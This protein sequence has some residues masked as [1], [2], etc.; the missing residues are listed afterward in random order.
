MRVL[1]SGGTGFIG[2]PFVHQ[3]LRGRHTVTVLCRDPARARVTLPDSVALFRYDMVTPGAPDPVALEGQDLFVHLA[4]TGLPNYKNTLHGDVNLPASLALCRAVLDAGIP[5]L[6]VAGTCMEFGVGEGA[7]RPDEEPSPTTAYAAAKDQ[8]RRTLVA[9]RS[10]RAFRLQWV[11]IFYVYGPGQ[12]PNSLIAQLDAA[13]ARGDQEFPMS[14][15]RH[16]R[17]YLSVEDVAAGLVRVVE[18]PDLEGPLHVCSG[19]PTTIRDLVEAHIRCR[20]VTIRPRPGAFPDPEGEP[21]AFWGV[22]SV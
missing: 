1:V 17:D 5:R 16:A 22:P 8:L 3:L 18:R 12:N 2:R 7:R 4:W 13:I 6:L 15:G 19:V 9:W 14:S 11:R 10:D 21:F 20:G